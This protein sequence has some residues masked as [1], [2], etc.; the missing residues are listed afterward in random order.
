MKVLCVAEKNSIAKEV[1]KILGGGRIQISNSP[2]K[3]VKNYQFTFNFPQLGNCDVTMTSVAGHLSGMDFPDAYKW[4]RCSPGKLFEAPIVITMSDDQKKIA[5]NIERLGRTAQKLMIWTDCDREGEYIGKEILDVAR[6][7]NPNITIDNTLRAQ[8]SHLE[9]SHVLKAAREPIK[10]DQNAINAVE[11]RMELD[12]RTGASFTRFLCD[13]FQKYKNANLVDVV[14]YGSCQFPTVGFVVDRFKRIKNFV[15]EEFWYLDISVRKGKITR[16]TWKKNRLFDRLAAVVL[17]QKCM[18]NEKGTITNIKSSPSTKWKPLPLT[19]VELQKGCSMYFKMS[20]KE[21]LEVAEKLYQKGFLSYPRTETNVYP[22]T[23]DLKALIDKQRPDQ[24]W[25]EYATGLLDG[26]LFDT[27]RQGKKND[28]AHPPIHPV[29]YLNIHS[30]DATAT[31]KKVYEFVVRHFLA[32][33][34]KNAKGAS[35]N[36]DLTWGTEK[37]SASGLQVLELNYLDIYKY[38]SWKSSAELPEFTMN[39]Q[40]KINSAE[41][42]SGKTSPPQHITETELIALMDAN[43]IGTDATIADHIEKVCN[44]QYIIKKTE[45]QKKFLVPSTLGMALVDGFE[46]LNLR[47]SLTKPFLRKNMEE[48]LKAICDGVK[49]KNDVSHEM[50]ELYRES[51]ALS[52]QH[53]NVILNAYQ[54]YRRA[55]GEQIIA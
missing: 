41:L 28:E 13:V 46:E 36:V 18:E 50:V 22:K 39:E 44:R 31:E 55:L 34:S 10:L 2:Y 21:S 53:Q 1:A 38:Q 48:E 8:F 47:N 11:T 42:K 26:D 51:F 32:T 52:V 15:P 25:G 37:F 23:M 7:G 6:K 27:P 54:R 16:F 45:R 29:N 12:L 20:A 4:G 33:C 40:V 35:T 19:T 24:V 14:S 3:Y 49:R 5:Q 17:Y 30:P 9:R 43:G